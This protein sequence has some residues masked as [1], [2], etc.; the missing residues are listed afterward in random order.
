MALEPVVVTD[1]CTCGLDVLDK[2]NCGELQ[3]IPAL[4]AV[5]GVSTPLSRLLTVLHTNCAVIGGTVVG[6]TGTATMEVAT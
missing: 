1:T 2:M 3:L 4:A 6:R 5:V